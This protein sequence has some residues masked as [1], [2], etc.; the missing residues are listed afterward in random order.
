M[1]PLRTIS[2][3]ISRVNN[4]IYHLSLFNSNRRIRVVNSKLRHPNRSLIIKLIQSNTSRLPIS[5]SR[6]RQRVPRVPRENVTYTRVI[7]HGTSTPTLRLSRRL[8]RRIHRTRNQTFNSLRSRPL[9]RTI[10]HASPPTRHFGPLQ[11]T[12]KPHQ[13][14]SQRPRPQL[15]NRHPR[16]RH[17]NRTISLTPRLN[18]FNIPRRVTRKRRPTNIISS[19]SRPFIGN[20]LIKTTKL[21]RKLGNRRPITPLSHTL[22][23]HRNRSQRL[24]SHRIRKQ[25]A[26]QK[27]ILVN[28]RSNRNN[29]LHNASALTEVPWRP[30]GVDHSPPKELAQ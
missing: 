10:I 26:L 16:T 19:T 2:T 25:P 23:N 24:T 22:G 6:I 14:I 3:R 15:F 29:L 11:V 21:R 17:R 20:K 30:M 18:H 5:L 1:R 7:R 4:I 13:R 12:S 9:N 8:S 28:I 27:Y